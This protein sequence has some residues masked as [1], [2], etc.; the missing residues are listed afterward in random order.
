[1]SD[2]PPPLPDWDRL[3]TMPEKE[4]I[5]F[6]NDYLKLSEKSTEAAFYPIRAQIFMQELARREQDKQTKQMRFLTFLITVFTV[7]LALL[8]MKHQ[9][10]P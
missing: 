4:L 5:V 3:S 10:G 7:L 8:E 2:E 1:M 9:A 6:T